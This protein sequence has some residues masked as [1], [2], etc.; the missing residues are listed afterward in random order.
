MDSVLTY[1]L[2]QGNCTQENFFGFK[3]GRPCILLKLNKI[4][5]W[6]PQP[7]DPLYPQ[8]WPE[9]VPDHLAQEINKVVNMTDNK[10]KEEQEKYVSSKFL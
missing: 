1:P 10:E 6:R 3:A 5:G 9:G 4:I 2:L 8:D 7:L